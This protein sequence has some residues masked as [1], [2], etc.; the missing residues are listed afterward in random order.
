M[1]HAME[2]DGANAELIAHPDL[3]AGTVLGGTITAVPVQS[4]AFN[5]YGFDRLGMTEIVPFE[6]A[7]SGFQR[8]ACAQC[9]SSRVDWTESP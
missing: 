2:P 9:A 1:R 5:L 4:P 7:S 3:T 6:N 8:R